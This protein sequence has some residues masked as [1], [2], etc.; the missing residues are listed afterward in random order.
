MDISGYIKDKAALS[1]TFR[2]YRLD[3]QWRELMDVLES[4]GI[5][6]KL[7]VTR[8]DS[9]TRVAADIFFR[10]LT[11]PG[12]PEEMANLPPRPI[13]FKAR[14]DGEI[15]ILIRSYPPLNKF[16]ASWGEVCEAL[17][18]ELNL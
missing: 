12:T 3:D 9:D 1:R 4:E 14:Y 8:V 18:Q 15:W 13:N 10:P 16:F 7:H 2:R 6:G 11:G 5:L 17:E